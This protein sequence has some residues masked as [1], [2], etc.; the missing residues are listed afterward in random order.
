MDK[1]EF[2]DKILDVISQLEA[3]I[4]ELGEKIETIAEDAKD[5]C[6]E[7]IESLKALRDE[8]SAKLANYEL[9]SDNRWDVVKES[10]QSFM[11]KVAD[12]WEEDFAKVKDAFRKED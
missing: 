10:A 3:R 7:K 6:L 11:S 4:D 5:E 8:L 2:R 12:A 9:A 1:Q